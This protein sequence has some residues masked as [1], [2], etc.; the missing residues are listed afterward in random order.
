MTSSHSFTRAAF[1]LTGV[2]AALAGLTLAGCKDKDAQTTTGTPAGT[3]APGT[4]SASVS[5]D[6]IVVGEFGSFT[7]D[8]ADFGNQTHDGIQ[9][10]IDETNAAGGIERDGKKYQLEL[11]KDDDKSQAP[12]AE[13]VVKGLIDKYQ[14]IA[15]LGEVAS[16]ASI[17]G[18][19]VC[20]AKGVPM[21]SPSSTRVDVTHGK[22][23]LFRVCFIDSYQAAVVARFAYDGLKARKAAILTNNS[24][25][26]STG[27][28]DEFEKAFTRYGGQIIMKQTYAQNDQDYRSQLTAIKASSP[29]VILI[30]GYYNDA[31]TIAKQARELGITIPL[32]GGDGWSSQQLFPIAGDG[33]ENCYFS[34][35]MSV[36]DPKPLVQDF[37]KNYK[38]KFNADP[39]SMSALGYDAA[40]LL[41]ASL[42]SAKALD[43]DSVK[44]AIAG[45]KNFDGVS[46][47]ITINKDHDAEKSAVIIQVKNKKFNYFTTVPDPEK[48]LVVK[49]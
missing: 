43:H 14:P 9:L 31:G 4:A 33:A 2:F 29:D 28:R 25:S 38:A 39:T 19:K 7:G 11:D 41:I 24:Q 46:G 35:H 16:S 13:T 34:D 40:K 45:T 6:K 3:T 8:Q 22:N 18:G 32:L 20:E 30:P 37:V 27:F 17:A 12:N 26:Y 23:Y 49:K 44:D 5:G 10:A 1:R 47:N 15:I 48:P 21:I 36:E 42:K